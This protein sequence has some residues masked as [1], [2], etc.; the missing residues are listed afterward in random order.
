MS[1]KKIIVVVGATGAQGGGLARAVLADPDGEFALRAVTRDASS[2]AARALAEAGAEVVTA[3]LDDEGSVLKALDDAYGAFFVTAY[4]EYLSVE[5]EQAQ[6]ANMAQAARTAGLRHVIWS[7][8]PDTREDVPLGSRMPTLMG[9]YNV[10]HF[11]SK[12]EANRFFEEAGVPT[13]F[14]N[15]TYYFEGF[16]SYFP[17]TRG[18]DGRLAITLPMGE[19][20]LSGIASEDIGKIALAIF[21]QG[22]EFVGETLSIAGE[23][24]TGEQYAAALSKELGEEIVYRS[25]SFDDF[26]ALGFPGADDLGNM[27][28]YYYEFEEAFTGARN[29]DELRRLHPG[30]QD[31]ATW[32]H[33]NRDRFQV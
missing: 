23:H 26:R 18:E 22:D 1:D 31:F 29:L 12:G 16:L 27:F 3:D 30:L 8:L 14:L 28:Q 25:M 33:L 15:T 10:P 2:E 17:P 20:K 21:K 5:R 13:T 24:L 4:W 9:K 19:R 11:D 32:A 6:A 7:T